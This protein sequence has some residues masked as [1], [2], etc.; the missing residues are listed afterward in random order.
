MDMGFALVYGLSRTLYRDG[1]KCLG[2][3]GKTR[4]PSNDHSNDYGAHTRAWNDDCEKNDRRRTE[5][6][7]QTYDAMRAEF[8]TNAAA[9]DYSR[10]RVHSDG[11]YALNHRWA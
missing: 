4:C 11:G 8:L 7:A 2:D 10:R 5:A 1:H 3:K 6:N 9:R